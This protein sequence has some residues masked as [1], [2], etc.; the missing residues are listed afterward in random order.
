MTFIYIKSMKLVAAESN[1]DKFLKRSE[2]DY[3]NQIIS[4]CISV[5]R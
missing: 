2:R 4:P 3:R 1:V 5:M